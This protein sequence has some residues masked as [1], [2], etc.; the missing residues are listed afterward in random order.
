MFFVKKGILDQ[1]SSIYKFYELVSSMGFSSE[2][3]PMF[4]EFVSSIGFIKDEYKFNEFVSSMGFSSEIDPMFREFVS[5]LG[6]SLPSGYLGLG[7][8]PLSLGDDLLTLE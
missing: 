1:E 5:S 4:R 7:D 6:F 2:F 3:D 8:A